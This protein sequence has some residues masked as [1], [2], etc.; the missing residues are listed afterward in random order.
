[1]QLIIWSLNN[2]EGKKEHI[3]VMILSMMAQINSLN[4]FVEIIEKIIG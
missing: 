1:M 3:F 4:H 2:F